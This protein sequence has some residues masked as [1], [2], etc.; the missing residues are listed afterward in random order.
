M[1]SCTLQNLRYPLPSYC[2]E[3]VMHR[4][5]VMHRPGVQ[6]PWGGGGAQRTWGPCICSPPQQPGKSFAVHRAGTNFLFLDFLHRCPL[7]HLATKPH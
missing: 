1:S 5:K 4:P 2:K 6:P 3:T 7:H